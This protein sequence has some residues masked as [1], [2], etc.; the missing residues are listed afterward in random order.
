MSRARS[1]AADDRALAR[2]HAR[3]GNQQSL[4][5]QESALQKRRRRSSAVLRRSVASA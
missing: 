2:V 4:K 5:D 1:N 3:I